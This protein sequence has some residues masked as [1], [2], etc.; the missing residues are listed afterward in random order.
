MSEYKINVKSSTIKER[1][2]KR[3]MLCYFKET[4]FKQLRF[5]LSI[6]LGMKCNKPIWV[7]CLQNGKLTNARMLFR[8][9]GNIRCRMNWCEDL[10]LPVE[11]PET[12]FWNGV[13]R[14]SKYVHIR[15]NGRNI[16]D[17]YYTN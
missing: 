2:L 13:R 15:T 1:I 9:N 8:Y 4:S 11:N 16:Y 3:L 14:Y 17:P 10:I 12:T 7:S 6:V 5:G